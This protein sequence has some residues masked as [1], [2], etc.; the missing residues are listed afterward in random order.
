MPGQIQTFQR[1]SP[2]TLDFVTTTIE[3]KIGL[4]N[5]KKVAIEINKARHLDNIRKPY[6][7]NHNRFGKVV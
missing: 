1:G 6:T 3:G 4:K 5:P 2:G 7:R